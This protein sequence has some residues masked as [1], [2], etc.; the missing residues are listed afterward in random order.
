MG[1]IHSIRLEDLSRELS[2]LAEKAPALARQG[3]IKAAYRSEKH[4]VR[5]TDK[6]GVVDRGLFRRS[7]IVEE[8][9]D[10]AT[11]ANTAPYAAPIEEG[12]RPHW[13]PLQPLIEWVLR[14]LMGDIAGARS[15]GVLIERASRLTKRGR[16]GKR[17]E[18]AGRAMITAVEVAKGV[19]RKIARRGTEAKG[20]MRDAYPE[21]IDFV[22]DEVTR[23]LNQ[24]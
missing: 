24:T 5:V 19:Q 22:E 13:P 15:S 9:S 6:K 14:N 3:L 7:W 21:Y 8:E 11:L 12:S 10:G 17:A 16:L 2:S 18:R 23:K 20:V 1:N 4:T